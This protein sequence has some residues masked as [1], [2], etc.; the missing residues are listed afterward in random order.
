MKLEKL[1]VPQLGTNF[2][3]EGPAIGRGYPG[4][5]CNGI[6]LPHTTGRQDHGWRLEHLPSIPPAQQGHPDDPSLLRHQAG[7]LGVLQE[8]D[9]WVFPNY[10]GQAA[11]K[12]RPGAVSTG[13]NDSGTGMGG[14]QSQP[15]LAVRP[16]VEL[17]AQGQ[18]LVNSV[19][20]FVCQDP[21]GL[22]LGQPI[23]RRQ[24]VSSVLPRAIAG[25][26]GNCNTTLSPRAGA[27]DQRFL[28]NEDCWNAL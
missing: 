3:G 8:L 27:V 13:M 1:D 12:G 11:D 4:V 26:Q 2:M 28:S 14:F 18:Q 17:G 19:W 9:L 5:G 21:Y 25:P 20:A 10:L 7:D 24:S 23:A 6:E 22:W 16:A 15:Q